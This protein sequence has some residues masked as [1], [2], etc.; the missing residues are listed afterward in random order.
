LQVLTIIHNFDLKRADGTTAA[1]RLFDHSFPDVFEWVSSIWAISPWR[2]GLLKHI[3]PNPYLLRFSRLKLIPIYWH[4]YLIAAS[5]TSSSR[6]DSE[7]SILSV[8]STVLQV[9]L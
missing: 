6:P 7:L 4:F 8:K 9:G 5:Y 2:G 1:E 3:N